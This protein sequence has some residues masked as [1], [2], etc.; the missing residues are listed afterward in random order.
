MLK[1]A[2]IMLLNIVF[3]CVYVNTVFGEIVEVSPV[4]RRYYLE[5]KIELEAIPGYDIEEEG[6]SPTK[7]IFD[8]TSVV[9]SKRYDIGYSPNFDSKEY[10]LSYNSGKSKKDEEVRKQAETISVNKANKINR[11]FKNDKE[12]IILYQ[13]G[14]YSMM[15]NIGFEKGN[16]RY[17][18]NHENYFHGLDQSPSWY[19]Y[20]P[21][22]FHH[23]YVIPTN[24]PVGEYKLPIFSVVGILREIKKGNSP[25]KL[26]DL[27]ID[28]IQKDGDKSIISWHIPETELAIFE[29]TNSKKKKMFFQEFFTAEGQMTCDP[30]GVIQKYHTQ[31][32][33]DVYLNRIHVENYHRIS[34]GELLNEEFI[35]DTRKFNI[36]ECGEKS[37][38]A[39]R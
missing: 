26:L 23:P 18:T 17:E 6:T 13:I 35:D 24:L 20:I 4:Q 27:Q 29:T 16:F 14:V 1:M 33:H 8:L 37:N 36:S 9:F 39:E 15:Y 32:H 31:V 25:I 38:Q 30:D 2:K 7:K 3:T 28:N 12:N 5:S 34:N 11:K 19:I 22:N 10:V 21:Y